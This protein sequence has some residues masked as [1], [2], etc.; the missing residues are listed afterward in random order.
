M[1]SVPNL[2]TFL[3]GS[4]AVAAEVND[5]FTKVK[6]FVEASLVQI[7]G[8]VKAGTAAIADSAVT[9]AKIN[10]GAVTMDKINSALVPS[11]VPTG[12]VISYIGNAAPTGWLMCDGST[13]ANMSSLYPELYAILGTNVLPDLKLRVPMGAGTGAAVR[14]AGGSASILETNLPAHKHGVSI[15]SGGQSA[16]HSHTIS[17]TDNGHDHNINATVNSTSSHVH[18]NLYDYVAAGTNGAPSVGNDGIINAIQSNTTGISASAGIQSADHTHAVSGDT[19]NTGGGTDYR[20]PYY[21]V[22]YIIKAA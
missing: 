11:L 15:T 18:N 20:Q 19:A 12:S 17:I 7:D 16:N 13:I 21:A 22:N 14:T 10:N 5:N 6:T 2:N 4:T 9:T 1:A 3:D 8:S